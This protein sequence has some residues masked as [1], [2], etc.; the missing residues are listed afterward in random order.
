MFH[1]LQVFTIIIKVDRCQP[2]ECNDAMSDINNGHNEDLCTSNEIKMNQ[3][4]RVLFRVKSNF[5]VVR[6]RKRF[7]DMGL[8]L[9]VNKCRAGYCSGNSYL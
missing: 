5:I 4:V 6:R 7:E 1:F 3:N 9:G 2:A 8:V